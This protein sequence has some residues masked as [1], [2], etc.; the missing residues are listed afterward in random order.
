MH[1]QHQRVVEV[2]EQVLAVRVGR[3]EG[4]SVQQRRL[5]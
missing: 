1:M 4:V 3:E 5:R 2:Q